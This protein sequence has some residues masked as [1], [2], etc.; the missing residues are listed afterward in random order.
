MIGLYYRKAI[1]DIR[2]NRFLAVVTTLTIALSVLMASTIAL[3]IVNTQDL[4]AQWKDGIRIMVYLAP[5]LDPDRQKGVGEKIRRMPGVQRASFISKAEAMTTLRSQ[6]A[7]Q[8]AL[9]DNLRSNPLPDAY[10]VQMDPVHQRL[11]SI[12]TLSKALEILPGVDDVEYGQ[13]W[14]G[15]FIRLFDVAALVG[16]ALAGLF[17]MAAV[18]FVANTIRLVI[19]SRRDEIDIMRLVGA[20]DRLIKM[21]FYTEGII[22]G[23]L[24]GCLGLGVLGAAFGILSARMDTGLTAGLFDVRFL[25]P[26][27][28]AVV[29]ASSMIVGWL[30]C[31]LSLQQ[32][33]KD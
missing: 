30:G 11:G 17:F 26:L 14:L 15:R 32:H 20:E 3:L 24:G 28:L 5:D 8:G 31:F 10:L 22:L 16:Y 21:P 29:V 2:T 12:E 33:L 27:A 4:M 7:R 6:M 13:Q 19:Y 18:F 25:P 9:L 23:F 1:E